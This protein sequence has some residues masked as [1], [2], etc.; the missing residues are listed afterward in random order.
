MPIDRAPDIRPDWWD[1]QTY[2]H[3]CALEDA[4]LPERGMSPQERAHPTLPILG[5]LLKAVWW[6][7]KTGGIEHRHW[8]AD[9]ALRMVEGLAEDA[10]AHARRS[11]SRI[12]DQDDDDLRAESDY[13]AMR[14]D[15]QSGPPQACLVS[16]QFTVR[17]PG[18]AGDTV[19]GS[20]TVDAGVMA[21]TGN[22]PLADTDLLGRMDL[23][24]VVR[25]IEAAVG[26]QVER[27]CPDSRADLAG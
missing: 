20:I 17:L 26:R 2:L 12:T 9:D 25:A 1:D 23:R 24:A 27:P 3:L 18:Y 7:G 19:G 13:T 14:D 6:L 10:A 8:Q 11:L 16:A 15:P 5:R 22:G 4:A 21:F